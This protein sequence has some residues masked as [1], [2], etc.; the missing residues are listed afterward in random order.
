MP[1]ASEI[2]LRLQLP[3]SWLAQ[4]GKASVSLRSGAETQVGFTV[5]APAGTQVWRARV[6]VDLTAGGRALGQ[7]AEAL[8][9][10]E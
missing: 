9:D 5:V 2:R 3:S 1:T 6:G 8:V 7:L 4:P 10:L